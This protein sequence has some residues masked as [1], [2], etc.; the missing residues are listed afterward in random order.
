MTGNE[1]P[2][3]RLLLAIA[4]VLGA[5]ALAVPT[6][7]VS[8]VEITGMTNPT[9]DSGATV[10][11]TMTVEVDDLTADGN[12]D[13]V[14]VE[15]PDAYAANASFDTV[16][17]VNRTSNETVPISSSTTVVD[18]PDDDGV[19]DTLRTGLSHDTDYAYD[20]VE[21]TYQFD[22]TH[23]TLDIDVTDPSVDGQAYDITVYANDSNGSTARNTAVD[24]ITV[25]PADDGSGADNGAATD[26]DGSDTPADGS[27][28]GTDAGGGDG[29]DDD[30]SDGTQTDAS[31]GATPVLAV[32]AIL[33]VLLAGGVIVYLRQ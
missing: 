3:R 31:S 30:G 13:L 17:F 8:D 10:S 21:G 25:E 28:G 27:P 2:R 16:Q 19:Q 9:V 20:D 4:V 14:F 7:A 1:T 12:E 33:L 22:L 15:F 29:S 24:E 32:G 5:A 18:G 23:P 26:T 6:A 11:H